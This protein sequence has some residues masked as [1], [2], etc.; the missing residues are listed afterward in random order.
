MSL[1]Q[2]WQKLIIEQFLRDLLD[3]KQK[4][5]PSGKLFVTQNGK[6]SNQILEDFIYSKKM[7]EH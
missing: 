6:K 3:R 1:R 2:H 7:I 5:F 4:N